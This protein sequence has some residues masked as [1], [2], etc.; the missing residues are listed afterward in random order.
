MG[1]NIKSKIDHK[2]PA[3][4]WT[5]ICNCTFSPTVS[6]SF[7]SK[8]KHLPRVHM[9][10][11]NL[12]RNISCILFMEEEDVSGAHTGH[13]PHQPAHVCRPGSKLPQVQPAHNSNMKHN[14]TTN[15]AR[16]IPEGTQEV[17]LCLDVRSKCTHLHT[18]HSPGGVRGS[19]EE[20][21]HHPVTHVETL[22]YN[23]ERAQ[24]QI[25]D[26]FTLDFTPLSEWLWIRSHTH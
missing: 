6:F 18:E 14:L 7:P 2:W 1:Y 22:L 4:V 20:I 25:Q 13:D 19:D 5:S 21:N 8:P 26:G 3:A 11:W 15:K 10:G 9:C 12:Y 17:F 24:A 23:P 16:L